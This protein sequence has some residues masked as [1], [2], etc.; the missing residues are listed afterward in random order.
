MEQAAANSILGEARG[1]PPL[2]VKQRRWL[3]TFIRTGNRTQAAKEA[4]Y[5]CRN[6]RG[7]QDIGRQNY[8]KLRVYIKSLLEELGLDNESLKLELL[9]LIRAR[10]PTRM[11]VRGRVEDIDALPEG[12]TV[13]ATAE[14][15][16][17]GGKQTSIETSILQFDDIDL[18]A[19]AKGLDL[20]FKLKG[21]YPAQKV[22]IGDATVDAIAE[23]LDK[24]DGQTQDLVMN[25]RKRV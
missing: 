1:N 20:A 19:K 6:E 8:G 10:K 2:T 9:M 16:V 12:V 7:Y 23:I 25:G 22:D 21:S 17:H 5:R 24:I 14:N 13:V 18:N 4:G 11:T 3:R 15:T